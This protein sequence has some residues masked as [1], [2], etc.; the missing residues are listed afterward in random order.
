MADESE[1][2]YGECRICLCDI[3]ESSYCLYKIHDEEE[4]W[5]PSPI[6]S[7]CIEYLRNDQWKQFL[8]LV[9]NADCRA[10]VLRL[11]AK[12]PLTV[13]EISFKCTL[14]GDEC[15]I[16]PQGSL[17][18]LRVAGGEPT[19]PILEGAKQGVERANYIAHLQEFAE[20]LEREKEEENAE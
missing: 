15:P 6:C 19:V 20:L 13:H 12:V 7:D 4:N 5:S 2:T 17:A 18:Q 1:Q 10:A 3:D 11:C 14:H 16:L 8:N 9:E